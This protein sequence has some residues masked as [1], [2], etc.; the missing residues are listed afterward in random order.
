M[1]NE[2]VIRSITERGGGAARVAERRSEG[3]IEDSE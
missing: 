2:G 1:G 3:V